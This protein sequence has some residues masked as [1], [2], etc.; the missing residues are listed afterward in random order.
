[1]DTPD[2]LELINAALEEGEPENG[3]DYGD[4]TFPECRCGRDWHGLPITQAMEDMALLG[5]FDPAYRYAEDASPILCPGSDVEGPLLDDLYDFGEPVAM[6]SGATARRITYG[7][8]TIHEVNIPITDEDAEEED[9][10]ARAHRIVSSIWAALD[11]LLEDCDT[12]NGL[13]SV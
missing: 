8:V 6:G 3:Y 9:A 2:I 7:G 4:P 5:V 13:E 10:V 1:M 11:E 12:Q